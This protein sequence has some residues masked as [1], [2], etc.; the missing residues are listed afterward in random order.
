M[1]PCR[2]PFLYSPPYKRSRRTMHAGKGAANSLQVLPSAS[3][4]CFKTLNPPAPAAERRWKVQ[5]NLRPGQNPYTWQVTRNRE[6]AWQSRY[7]GSVKQDLDAYME[8]NGDWAQLRL[9]EASAQQKARRESASQ[10]DEFFEDHQVEPSADGG[11]NASSYAA[12]AS[13]VSPRGLPKPWPPW[14]PLARDGARADRLPALPIGCAQVR[15]H[16]RQAQPSPAASAA[17]TSSSAAFCAT[18]R[19]PQHVARHLGVHQHPGCGHLGYAFS[20]GGHPA[21]REDRRL[22]AGALSVR[23]CGQARARGVVLS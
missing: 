17:T 7:R 4:V 5:E 20:F 3:S 12:Y 8:R 6:A 10:V 2:H 21:R 16:V 14:L 18:C 9:S 15:G 19:L 13:S 23:C 22:R 11:I 1:P